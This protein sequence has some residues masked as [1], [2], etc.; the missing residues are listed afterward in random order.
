MR[1]HGSETNHLPNDR[2][3]QARAPARLRDTGIKAGPD[4]TPSASV[5]YLAD[6]AGLFINPGTARS[7]LPALLAQ[8]V[9]G[10]TMR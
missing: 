9:T 8:Y 4:I 3:G 6:R 7:R 1:G 5:F 2:R 10:K